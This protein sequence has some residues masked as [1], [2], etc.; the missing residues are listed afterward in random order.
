M[1]RINR[2]A[3]SFITDSKPSAADEERESRIA[4]PSPRS[5]CVSK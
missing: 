1:S 5:L 4:S 2:S 3:L